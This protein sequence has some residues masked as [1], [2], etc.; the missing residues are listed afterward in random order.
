[1]IRISL[2]VSHILETSVDLIEPAVL[3]MRVDAPWRELRRGP[4]V[5]APA[6]VREVH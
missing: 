2:I 5:D 6:V 4:A 1:M 3:S